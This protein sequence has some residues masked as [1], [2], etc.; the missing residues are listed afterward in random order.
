MDIERFEEKQ[1]ELS[2]I[3]KEAG[4]LS[5]LDS[6]KA[7]FMSAYV[8]RSLENVFTDEIMTEVFM[9]LMN[10]RIGFL[11]DRNGKTNNRGQTKPLYTKEVVRTSIVD[12]IC[13]GLEPRNNQFNIIAGNMY[14]T[15]EGYSHLLRKLGAKHVL[16]V[17]QD[18]SAVD[19]NFAQMQ[20]IIGY[21]YK[22]E[23]SKLT[24]TTNVKKD[25]YSS[26]DQLKGKAEKRGKKALYEFLTGIDLG[27]ND[28]DYQE[29][30]VVDEKTKEMK[31]EKTKIINLGEL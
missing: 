16:T 30:Q 11:T 1:N 4:Q 25:S 14:P 17:G 23:K 13:F 8:L 31:V 10:K 9:P 3:L 27:D 5:L 2:T 26:Y 7:A 22:G 21:E 6:A 29:A 28:G 15:K 19:S 24:I 12:A 20:V 18:L